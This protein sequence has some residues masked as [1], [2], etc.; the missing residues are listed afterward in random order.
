MLVGDIKKM[1]VA[2]L[3]RDIKDVGIFYTLC[4]AAMLRICL[5]CSPKHLISNLPGDTQRIETIGTLRYPIQPTTD[6]EHIDIDDALC[7][8]VVSFVC[9]DLSTVRELKNYFLEDGMSIVSNYESIR[10]RESNAIAKKESKVG[11]RGVY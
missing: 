7:L 5:F 2:R 1:C 4:Y 6:D 9:S 8:A 3:D 10:L 11:G